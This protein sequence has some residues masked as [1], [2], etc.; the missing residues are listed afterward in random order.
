VPS[1]FYAE[2]YR[3]LVR[4][5]LLLVRDMATAEE[6]VQDSFVALHLSRRRLAD[7]DRAS[8]YLR[9]TVVSR[10][11]SVLRHRVPAGEHRPGSGMPGAEQGPATAREVSDVMTALHALPPRQREA[12]VLRQYADLSED[13]VAAAMGVSRS[14]VRRHTAD[15]MAALR[16]VLGQP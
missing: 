16:A 8:A 12:L 11:R 7:S 15:G 9:Q 14:A 4:L 10:S 5:A 2:H 13:Q 3:A 1:E 6:V